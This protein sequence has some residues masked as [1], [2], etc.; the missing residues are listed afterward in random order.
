M[1]APC[2]LSIVIVPLVGGGALRGLLQSFEREPGLPP[3]SEV[4]VVTREEVP[5]PTFATFLEPP[6][7]ATVPV[8]RALG[9]KAAR[10][11]VVALL[12][13][14]VLPARGWAAAVVERHRRFDAALAIGGTLGVA[15]GLSGPA[16]AL[17]A[18][19]Y[20][21]FL[22]EGNVSE[23][24]V[25]VPGNNMSFKR[26]FLTS[27]GLSESEGFREAEA[28]G[29]IQH[30]GIRTES[31]MG[32]TL[33]GIDPTGATIRSRFN[34]GRLYAGHRFGGPRRVERVARA[35]GSPLLAALMV[36]RGVRALRMGAPAGLR[37]ALPHLVWMSSAWS[38][39]ESVGYVLGP[40][41][42]E[43]HWR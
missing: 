9:L 12:E 35:L 15:R 32:A 40:G 27:L 22:R 33:T 36:G 42:A 19:E 25:R 34:H 10:G 5:A 4:L 3:G 31:D 16:L 7:G 41:N 37:K 6:A 43:E 2:E 8:R 29:R 13:D 21:P 1:T 23:H 39:G 20:G 17:A 24:G 18:L 26:R 28:V 38:L 30:G 11:S 14:T